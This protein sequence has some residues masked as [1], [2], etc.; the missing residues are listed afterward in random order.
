MRHAFKHWHPPAWAMA[1]G[2][3]K[4]EGYKQVKLAERGNGHTEGEQ[5][6]EATSQPP[7]PA[8]EA[9]QPSVAS[10][11]LLP[12]TEAAQPATLSSFSHAP[13]VA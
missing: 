3:S 2:K 4:P 5:P 12:A 7:P 10:L 1:H 13:E 8:P 6:S 9:A 11:S